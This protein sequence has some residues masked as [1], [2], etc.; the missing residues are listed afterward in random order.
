MKFDRSKEVLPIEGH[1]PDPEWQKRVP[2][3]NLNIVGIEKDFDDDHHD[4]E[5]KSLVLKAKTCVPACIICGF[6]NPCPSQNPNQPCPVSHLIKTGH[7]GFRAF[8]Q[9]PIPVA[10]PYVC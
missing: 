3:A 1:D 9:V 4:D 10:L 2:I 8:R 7:G 5:L 6:R